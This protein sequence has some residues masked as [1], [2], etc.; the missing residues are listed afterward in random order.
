[1]K[2]IIGLILTLILAGCTA[3]SYPGNYAKAE[4]LC[5]DNGG[6]KHLYSGPV[7]FDVDCKNG[8]R[9]E[10]LRKLTE[11]TVVTDRSTNED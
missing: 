8:A 4:E 2:T 3:Y 7:Y 11:H 9:F 5:E 6:V 1:M 10:N